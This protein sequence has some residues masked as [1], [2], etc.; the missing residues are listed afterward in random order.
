MTCFL[1]MLIINEKEFLPAVEMTMLAFS[2]VEGN[3]GKAAVTLHLKINFGVTPTEE[4]S[5]VIER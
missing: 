2:G 4:R 5:L 1:N 3:G